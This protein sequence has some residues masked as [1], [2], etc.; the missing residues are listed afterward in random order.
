MSVTEVQFVGPDLF[1]PDCHRKLF[2]ANENGTF[3][4]AGKASIESTAVAEIDKDGN[5]H[6]SSEAIVTEA[7]CYRRNCRF[8]RWLRQHNPRRA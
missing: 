5:I 3:M 6:P 2:G 1:C 8:K 7:T 4:I